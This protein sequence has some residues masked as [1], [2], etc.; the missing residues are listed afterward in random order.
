MATLTEEQNAARRE[1]RQR[2]QEEAQERQHRQAAVV[3]ARYVRG[4]RRYREWEATEDRLRSLAPK[5]LEVQERALSQDTDP[6]LATT[7]A[8]AVLRAAG[9][10]GLERPRMPNRYAL[11]L[12]D[13]DS[14]LENTDAAG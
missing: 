2:A 11:E 7:V 4:Y 3:Q 5:A 1:A 10:A 14:D 8:V 9:L 6:K 13:V 12:E